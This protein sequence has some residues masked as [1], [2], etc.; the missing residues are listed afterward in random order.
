MCSGRN[1]EGD[2][3]GLPP[4]ATRRVSSYSEQ[5]G[6]NG[7]PARIARINVQSGRVAFRLPVKGNLHALDEV[8]VRAVAAHEKAKRVVLNRL[9]RVANQ[10]CG[11]LRAHINEVQPPRGMQREEE[12]DE[13]GEHSYARNLEAVSERGSRADRIERRAGRGVRAVDQHAAIMSVVP[14]VA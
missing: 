13:R 4:V 14:C 11:G 10:R 6:S 8:T 7:E 2:G 12:E 3:E 5:R 1:N 9:H